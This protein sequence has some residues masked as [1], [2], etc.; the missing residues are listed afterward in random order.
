MRNAW[1]FLA[2]IFFAGYVIMWSV[3]LAVLGALVVGWGGHVN[4]FHAFSGESVFGVRDLDGRMQARLVNVNFSPAL[5]SMPGQPRPRRLLLRLEVVNADVF[6]GTEGQGRVRLDAW[7]LEDQSDIMAPPLYTIIAPGRT[8]RVEDDA[9]LV[10]ENGSRRSV[11]A[12]ND[13]GWLYDSDGI[14]AG[15]TDGGRR[16]MI[17]AV[18]AGEEMPPGSVAVVSYASPQRVMKRLLV[19]ASDPTRAR[20]LRTSV[21]LIR[22]MVR[23]DELGRRWLDLTLPA[24]IIRIPFLVNELDIEHASVPPGLALGEI[25]PWRQQP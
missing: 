9:V 20:L 24:G 13:G 8:G 11:Y 7:P 16:R 2:G 22:P 5:V 23:D 21:A 10:V 14:E 25:T 17:A 4:L 6:A 19:L 3:P 18:A 12:L 1:A 15:F